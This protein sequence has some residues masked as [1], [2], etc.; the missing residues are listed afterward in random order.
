MIYD[1]KNLRINAAIICENKNTLQCI[2]LTLLYIVADPLC[3]YHG[4]QFRKP[5][6]KERLLHISTMI[7][8]TN[9]AALK[10]RSTRLE[11]R[12]RQR[13]L[14]H[15]ELNRLHVVIQAGDNTIRPHKPDN[16]STQSKS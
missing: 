7:V 3:S 15:C 1:Y 13:C 5:C 4:P 16:N 11:L 6:F 8:I 12:S 14:S 9:Q 2:Y 10:T